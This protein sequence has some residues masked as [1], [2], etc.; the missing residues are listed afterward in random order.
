MSLTVEHLDETH[1]SWDTMATHIR[2][3]QPHTW[4]EVILRTKT[5]P[6]VVQ[7]SSTSGTK[8]PIAYVWFTGV[9]TDPFILEL[10]VCANPEWHGRWLTLPVL[11]ELLGYLYVDAEVDKLVAFHTDPGLRKVLKRIGFEDHGSFIHILDMENP[12]GIL[13]RYLRRWG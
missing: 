4:P 9:V 6:F 8:V 7:K 12:N 5:I 11:V 3:W 2:E 1:P 13:S 10:H